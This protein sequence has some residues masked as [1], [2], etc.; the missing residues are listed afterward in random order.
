MREKLSAENRTV[1]TLIVLSFFIGSAIALSESVADAAFLVEFG[2]ETLPWVYIATAVAVVL[3]GLGFTKLQQHVPMKRLY[4]ITLLLLAVG[5][6]ILRA[7]MSASASRAILFVAPT[8]ANLVGRL[9]QLIFWSLTAAMFTLTQSKRLIG[10][11]GIGLEI[12]LIVASFVTPLLIAAIGAPNLLLVAG[13]L[14]VLA[15]A[16]LQTLTVREETT[17]TAQKSTTQPTQSRYTLL[18]YLIVGLPTISFFL[19]GFT[20]YSQIDLRFTDTAQIASFL[21]IITGITSVGIL[22]CNLFLTSRTLQRIGLVGTLI[23]RPLSALSFAAAILLLIVLQRP[24]FAVAVSM[25]LADKLFYTS[26]H[27]P[28]SVMLFQP[29]APNVRRQI[30]SL[31]EST[32][33]PLGLGIAGMLILLVGSANTV[34]NAVLIIVIA[35]LWLTAIGAMRRSYPQALEKALQQRWL[36]GAEL[37]LNDAETRT[38]LTTKLQSERVRE[39]AYALTLL[40]QTYCQQADAP[41]D[42][43][44]ATLVAP[45]LNHAE[46]LLRHEAIAIVKRRRLAALLPQLRALVQDCADVATRVAAIDAITAVDERDAKTWLLPMLETDAI[47][48]RQAAMIGL[49][50]CGDGAAISVPLRQ[51]SEG[52]SADKQAVCHILANAHA[53]EFTHLLQQLLADDDSAV[54]KAAIRATTK[55]DAPDLQQQVL[56]FVTDPV[57]GNASQRAL[58]DAPP[59]A[60]PQLIAALDHAPQTISTIIAQRHDAAARQHMLSQLDAPTGWQRSLALDHLTAQSAELTELTEAMIQP[61]LQREVTAAATVLAALVAIEQ[62]PSLKTHLLNSSLAHLLITIEDRI[63]ALCSLQY[64]RATVEQMRDNLRLDADD[65][66]AFALELLEYTVLPPA[67]SLLSA[68][69]THGDFATRHAALAQ[70]VAAPERTPIQWL[71]DLIDSPSEPFTRW[72]Q[73]VAIHAVGGVQT[74]SFATA[75]RDNAASGDPLLA[76]TA[77]WVLTRQ[78]TTTPTETRSLTMLPTIEKVIILRTVDLFTTTPDEV[79]AD[80]A[81]L[82]T[83][84][85]LDAG[86]QLFAAGEYGESM[87]IIAHGRM[88]AHIGERTLNYL[89]ERSVFGEMAVLDPDVRVASISAETPAILLQLDREPLYELLESQPAV[90][91]GIITVLTRHL[92]ARVA[93][94]NAL[95]ERV[96]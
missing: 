41:C 43:E 79:L 68:L 10:V 58:I 67:K 9:G 15:V 29:L 24:L 20:Y 94:L 46:P 47:D 33:I 22:L 93:D 89:E 55:Y 27:R 85:R 3:I 5:L 57:L 32:I 37:Q 17:E 81:Q 73:A 6:I 35:L 34:F 62:E 91:R 87:Y 83:E 7:G 42:G 1:L 70:K 23:A 12:A 92:R 16:P 84:V 28:A 36:G 80:I 95:Q 74:D 78:E 40:E 2:A 60:T 71:G 63:F 38:L 64:E 39:V 69:F 90:A 51:M 44:L 25:R 53:P 96:G 4:I 45:L 82:L 11:I 19:I 56:T 77:Q 86:E 50:R 31:A 72:V 8:W 52:D 54:Q 65:K 13:G 14:L 88:R 49:L 61:H 21:A 66:H 48:V 76:E 30:Q 75:L 18:I 26:F 59:N